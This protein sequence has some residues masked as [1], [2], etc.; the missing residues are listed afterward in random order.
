MNTR[1]VGNLGEDIA[2]VH[3]KKNGYKIVERNFNCKFGEIDIIALHEGY[4]VFIEVKSRNTSM[5]GAPREAVTFYKQQHIISSAKY[6]LFKHRKTG[7]PVRFDVVEVVDGIAS[8]IADAF[9]I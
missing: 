5:F 2:A 3:L 9:R 7:V 4:Y 8:V 6:W 1:A